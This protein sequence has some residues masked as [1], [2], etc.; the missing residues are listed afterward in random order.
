MKKL[1]KILYLALML[2]LAVSF[3]LPQSIRMR[4]MIFAFA[5]A[6]VATILITEVKY[7]LSISVALVI[8][9]LEFLDILPLPYNYLFSH[10][11]YMSGAIL[12]TI[13]TAFAYIAIAVLVTQKI[14]SIWTK[15]RKPKD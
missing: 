10:G 5:L 15:S 9:L 8:F 1:S 7:A 13:L 14:S 11:M 12:I 3:V 4:Y 6:F 2:F